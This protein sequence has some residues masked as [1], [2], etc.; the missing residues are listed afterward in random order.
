M[1]QNHLSDA[2]L[3][4]NVP[5]WADHGLAVPNYSVHGQSQN[6][7]IRLLTSMIGR[8]L[9]AIM[10]HQDSRLSKPPSIATCANI[11]QMC[12]RARTMMAA[13]AKPSNEGPL[14]TPHT[15]PAPVDF[16][17]YPAPFFK[18]RNPWLKS[19]AEM[20]MYALT[21]AMQHTENA[22]AIDYSTVF[23]ADIGKYIQRIYSELAIEMF[24]VPA[25]E[26]RMPDFT[27]KQSHYAAFA[28]EKFVTSLEM[29][30]TVPNLVRWPTEDALQVL[31]AGIPTSSMPVLPTWPGAGVE[32]EGVASGGAAAKA[33]VPAP[34]SFVLPEPPGAP[35]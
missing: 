9:Q 30:D 23:A 35:D 20:A 7:A 11:A 6:S 18:V 25:A 32:V 2:F 19:W 17:I 31:A 24:N 8:N 13:K 4:Y 12:E 33:S 1:N 14:Q 29:V 21:D 28:P 15:S 34:A 16:L 22:I 10:F 5:G 26:A 27:L 3:W